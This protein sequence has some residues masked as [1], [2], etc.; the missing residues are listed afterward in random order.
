MCCNASSEFETTTENYEKPTGCGYQ[1]SG[2]FPWS[3]ALL[4]QE[5]SL[6]PHKYKCGISLIH[7]SVVVTAAHCLN[8]DG[9]LTVHVGNNPFIKWV[10]S[11]INQ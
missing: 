8:E 2:I 4:Y 3:G 10:I 5:N 6:S 11:F 7:V 1:F 9:I